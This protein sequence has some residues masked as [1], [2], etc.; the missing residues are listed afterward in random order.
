MDICTSSI[1]D[2]T[3]DTKRPYQYQ[4]YIFFKDKK[5]MTF[6]RFLLKK[7]NIVGDGRL[8]IFY[9]NIFLSSIFYN[10]DCNAKGYLN[11]LINMCKG[12]AG[13]YA[14]GNIERLNNILR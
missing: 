2:V 4:E 12:V 10:C 9:F 5:I 8:S 3:E 11:P 14:V 6:I 7:A 13:I 1:E